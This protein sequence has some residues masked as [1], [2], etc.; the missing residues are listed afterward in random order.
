[1]YLFVHLLSLFSGEVHLALLPHCARVLGITS[2][3][4]IDLEKLEEVPDDLELVPIIHHIGLLNAPPLP[5]F[6]L[7]HWDC[8]EVAW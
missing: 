6:P 5:L 2:D 1:V 3:F 8:L 4:S 7:A